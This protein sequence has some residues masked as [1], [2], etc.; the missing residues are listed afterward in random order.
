MRAGRQA[1]TLPGHSG[2]V[3]GLAFARKGALLASASADGSLRLWNVAVGRQ[4]AC[5][6]DAHRGGVACVT[7]APDGRQVATGGEADGT[8]KVRRM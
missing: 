4:T 1:G 8:V 5:V 3:C 6:A 7:F 2:R